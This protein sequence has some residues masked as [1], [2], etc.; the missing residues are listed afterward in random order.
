[1]RSYTFLCIDTG[2]LL[3]P[4]IYSTKPIGG[5]ELSL[6]LL[7]EGLC[8]LGHRVVILQP[9]QRYHFDG[10]LIFDDLRK[11]GDYLSSVDIVVINRSQIDLSIFPL[12]L[13]I[14]Y[15]SH[16]AYEQPILN[17]LTKDV[18][19]RLT[20]II[21]VSEWQAYTFRAFRNLPS[22][23]LVV[24][25]NAS[26]K[27]E[28][29]WGHERSNRN[30]VLVFASIPFKGLHVL[31]DLFFD[32]CMTTR[33]EDLELWIYSS[34]QLYDRNDDN[35]TQAVLSK[36]RTMKGVRINPLVPTIDLMN[37]FKRAHVYIHPHTYHET[38]GMVVVQ[39]MST[40]VIPVSTPKGAIPEI[41]TH[42][43][44]GLLT[45][46]PNIEEYK[47]YVEFVDLVA[48][49]LESSSYRLS[50]KATEVARKYN[51]ISVATRFLATIFGG[52][53]DTNSKAENSVSIGS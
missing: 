39:A 23:K 14:F 18:V 34:H 50:V 11:L 43:E 28:W 13:P 10:S 20:K 6:L 51:Y 41:I 31:P 5:S 25:P 19:D 45:T 24:V 2:L 4:K 7:A 46:G 3:Q 44:N 35:L 42:N 17:W 38:F 16:D 30:N 12:T 40:G 21:C 27:V 29:S 22:E 37:E 9:H 52:L 8:E 47:T 49:A 48:T 53:Y 33:R 32:I 26:L 15:F 36:L 1:M